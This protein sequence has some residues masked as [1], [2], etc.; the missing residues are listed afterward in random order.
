MGLAISRKLKQMGI[1]VIVFDI[2][3]PPDEFQ[4]FQVDIR[5]DTQIKEALSQLA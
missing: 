2:Q 5:S 1:Q 4:Y 3:E